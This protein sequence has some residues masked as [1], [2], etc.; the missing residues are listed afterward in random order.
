MLWPYKSF[1]LPSGVLRRRT[2]SPRTSVMSSDVASTSPIAIGLVLAT[3]LL[4]TLVRGLMVRLRRT[5]DGKEN[6][7]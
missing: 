6:D 1:S 5:P 2:M 3:S 7:L 4:I